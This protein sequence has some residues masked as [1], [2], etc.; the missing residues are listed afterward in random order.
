MYAPGFHW[1]A[2]R[3]MYAVV[4]HLLPQ[5]EDRESYK[6]LSSRVQVNYP[7]LPNQRHAHNEVTRPRQTAL[8]CSAWIVFPRWFVLVPRCI[9]TE[10]SPQARFGL[11][12]LGYKELIEVRFQYVPVHDINKSGSVS[13]MW[14]RSGGETYVPRSWSSIRSRINDTEPH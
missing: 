4:A 9:L 10:S 2:N 12:I 5:H 8:L 3:Q 1:G 11:G 7:G 6:L 14:G 13:L